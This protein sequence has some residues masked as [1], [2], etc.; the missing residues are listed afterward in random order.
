MSK[1]KLIGAS[2][3]FAMTTMVQTVQANQIEVTFT[4]NATA[5]GTYLTPLWVGFHDGSFDSFNVGEAASVGIS[6]IAELGN[7]M[8]LAGEFAGSGVGGVAGGAP[9]APGASVSVIL[10]LA[11]DGSNSY[12]SFAS[13]LLP[14]SDFFIG[15]DNAFSIASVLNGMGPLV[16][17]ITTAYDAGSEVND[18]TTSAG[19]GLFP[20]AGLPMTTAPA[21]AAENGVIT[22]ITGSAFN[23]FLNA[24]SADVSSFNFDNYSSIASIEITSVPEPT[25]LSMLLLGFAGLGFT[26]RKRAVK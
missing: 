22:P 6:T 20:A 16:F 24:G 13:M 17:D 19:N 11:A 23:G 5:G 7:P 1:V 3:V 21:G 12:L 14:S 2:L 26:R 10:D 8:P 15:N 9:I 25:T 4:N 18:F